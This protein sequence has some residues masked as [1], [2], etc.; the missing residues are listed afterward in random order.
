M[1][2]CQEM[3]IRVESV[4]IFFPAIGSV[5]C[6]I[7]GDKVKLREDRSEGNYYFHVLVEKLL[8]YKYHR[9]KSLLPVKKRGKQTLPE[10]FKIP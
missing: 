3:A 5:D 8:T 2:G 10:Y 4:G 1:D 6:N 9:N 7:F